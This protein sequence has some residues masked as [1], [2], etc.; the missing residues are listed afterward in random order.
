[1]KQIYCEV[2]SAEEVQDLVGCS[3]TAVLDTS[4]SD[5]EGLCFDCKDVDGNLVS[6]L[7]SE[8]GTFHLYNGKKKSIT[9]SQLGELAMLTGC[10]DID[11]VHFNRVDPMVETVIKAIGPNAANRVMTILKEIFPK[12]EVE[13][14]EWDLEGELHP[15][16]Q[17]SDP[18]YNLMI[19]V[20][21]MPRKV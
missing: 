9:K 8:E 6:F 7:V 10:S 14:T 15:M 20:A 3:I 18:D 1:M 2:C 17:C 11:S 21:V 4:G 12:L 5:G 19:V 16:Y 13:E